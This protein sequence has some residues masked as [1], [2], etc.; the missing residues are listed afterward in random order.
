MYSRGKN[1]GARLTD[2]MPS[3]K[4]SVA[5]LEVAAAVG[6][7]GKERIAE[8]LEELDHLVAAIWNMI[9]RPWR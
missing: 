3:A 4:E 7:V 8:C 9:H 1:C 2:A 6:Y 5:C